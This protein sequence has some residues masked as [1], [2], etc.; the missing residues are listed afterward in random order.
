M[1]NE[2]LRTRNFNWKIYRFDH[3]SVAPTKGN[4][5]CCT[6]VIHSSLLETLIPRRVDDTWKRLPDARLS[7]YALSFEISVPS[8]SE[9]NPNQGST[10][11]IMTYDIPK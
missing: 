4:V 1:K 3:V 10:D 2:K 6:D 5:L 8:D 7:Y 11:F 9:E